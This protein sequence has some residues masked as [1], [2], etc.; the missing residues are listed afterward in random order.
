MRPESDL[1]G[2]AADWLRYAYSDLEIA[3]VKEVPKVL[4]E[5]LCFHAQQAAEKALKAVLVA[6]GISFPRTHNLRTLLDLVPKVIEIPPEVEN[7]VILTEYAVSSRYP[8]DLEMIDEQEYQEAVQF[9]ESIVQWAERVT[10][11]E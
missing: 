11:S 8:G 5:T 4:L 7:G 9:A 6:N 10:R 1:A 3:R 2:S